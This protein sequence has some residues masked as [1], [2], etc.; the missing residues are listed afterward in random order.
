MNTNRNQSCCG[1]SSNPYRST[2]EN[3]RS[4]NMRSQNQGYTQSSMNRN[5][6]SRVES[7]VRAGTYNRMNQRMDPCGIA[8]TK[9]ID[10]FPVGMAYVPWQEFKDLYDPHQG[11]ARGTLF[12]ELD[13]PFYGK[14]GN[15]Q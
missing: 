3:P 4:G 8:G 1:G 12:K 9:R 13:Y 5:M 6:Q 10:Q 14:R 15:C 11:L 2:Q 7:E